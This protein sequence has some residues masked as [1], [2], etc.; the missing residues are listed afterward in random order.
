MPWWWMWMLLLLGASDAEPLF[1]NVPFCK[2]HFGSQALYF[3]WFITQPPLRGLKPNAVLSSWS[4]HKNED[5]NKVRWTRQGPCGE[6]KGQPQQPTFCLIF[7]SA[8]FADHICNEKGIGFTVTRLSLLSCTLRPTKTNSEYEIDS[9]GKTVVSSQGKG[10]GIFFKA[11][12]L[13]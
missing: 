8:S 11:E 2:T 1:K 12:L 5:K 10:R 9:S 3:D 13:L 6:Q 4:R 7:I